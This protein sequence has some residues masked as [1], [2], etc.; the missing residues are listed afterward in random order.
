LQPEAEPA[1]PPVVIGPSAPSPPA[2]LPP[3]PFL[4]A[5]NWPIALARGLTLCVAIPV[6]L[7]A[8]YLAI[9]LQG[10]GRAIRIAL[11]AFLMLVTPA[12]IADHPHSPRATLDIPS[13]PRQESGVGIRPV[14]HE[15]PD[16]ALATSLHEKGRWDSTSP[17]AVRCFRQALEA[18]PGYQPAQI[19][20]VVSLLFLGRLDEAQKELRARLTSREPTPLLAAFFRAWEDTQRGNGPAGV[21]YLQ[22]VRN[23]LGAER[24]DCLIE[25]IRLIDELVWF[26]VELESSSEKDRLIA[27]S[28]LYRVGRCK[29]L[30]PRLLQPLGYT[31]VAQHLLDTLE[32]IAKAQIDLGRPHADLD[33]ILKQLDKA[34]AAHPD[35]L[36][37]RYKA[38]VLL[39]RAVESRRAGKKEAALRDLRAASACARRFASGPTILPRSPLRFLGLAV[40]L[41]VDA[42]L[43][44]EERACAPAR[45]ERLLREL[46]ELVRE[47]GSHDLLRWQMM[48]LVAFALGK[49]SAE[50]A[51]SALSLWEASA[52]DPAERALVAAWRDFLARKPGDAWER[53][54][55]ALIDHPSHPALLDLRDRLRRMR[56]PKKNP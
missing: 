22:T 38:V 18:D 1:P 3:E 43:M 36:V 13:R 14:G 8:A 4:G 41:Q 54:R 20:L 34:E 23:S 21:R 37:A 28:V 24:T 25:L 40:G 39:R 9:V 7:L 51:S 35:A 12:W 19:A 15:K 17:G 2:A 44:D 45:L 55:R 53:V 42:V 52:A 27:R 5:K 46:P 33:H 10:R 11:L 6:V 56:A 29:S 49:V 16:R 47:G 48:P 30:F 31:P 26:L 50:L 32:A